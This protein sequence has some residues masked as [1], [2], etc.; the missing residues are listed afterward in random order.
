MK[1]SEKNSIVNFIIDSPPGSVNKNKRKTGGATSRNGHFRIRQKGEKMRFSPFLRDAA[2]PS[3]S[4]C[5]FLPTASRHIINENQTTCGAEA[6]PA[7]RRIPC[8]HVMEPIRKEPPEK[9]VARM[10]NTRTQRKNRSGLCQC[11]RRACPVSAEI[12]PALCRAVEK[13]A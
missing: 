3:V 6:T 10:E 2:R 7:N 13:E 12:A 11:P 1:I 9:D 5:P 8:P 4:S